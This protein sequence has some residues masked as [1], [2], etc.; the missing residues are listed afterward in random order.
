MIRKFFSI[1]NYLGVGILLLLCWIGGVIL[2]PFI[3]WTKNWSASRKYPLWWWFDDED[4]LYGAEYWRTAKGI[5]KK[6]WWVS[7]RW[8][9][10]RNPMWNAHTK[11]IPRTGMEIPKELFGKLER[12]GEE[13]DLMDSAVFHYVDDNGE[14]NGNVGDWLSIKHSYIGWTFVWFKKFD[15]L[16]W[17][18]SFAKQIWGKLALEIQIGVFHRYLFKIKLKWHNKVFE[19]RSVFDVS[20]QAITN[21]NNIVLPR[22]DFF[23]TQTDKF[24]IND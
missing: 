18:F 23:R 16:Y 15:K 7:C 1:L 12:A 9:A 17:R 5:T 20:K 10:W 4:G 2:Y 19:E 22:R 6:N 13:M 21:F 14:W 3:Y 11:I 24:I 8:S